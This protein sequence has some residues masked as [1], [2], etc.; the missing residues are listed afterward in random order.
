MKKILLI[1]VALLA[2][3]TVWAEDYITDVMVIGGNKTETDNLKASYT[4]Q[5]WTV[6][7]QD[8][9]AGAGSGSDYIYLLYKKASEINAGVNAFIT[10]FIVSTSSETVP[11][12]ITLSNGTYH[13]VTYDGSDYFK[14]NKGDLNS[15]CG[16]S[17][18]TIHL[19]YTKEYALNGKDYGTVKSIFFNA[20]ADGGVT[21][22]DGTTGYDLN[23]GCGSGSE[24]IYM[25]AD[26]SQGWI[27]TMNTAETEC[28]IKGFDGP[29]AN[30]REIS[31]PSS[32]DGAWVLGISGM[33]FSGFTN[34]ETMRFF[35]D[36]HV[37]QMPSLQGCS[38]FY[39][40]R[41]NNYD[42]RTPPSMTKIPG[43]AFAGTA[44][45]QISFESV[46]SIGSD[47]FAGCA[48][49]SSVTFNTSPVL[50][51]NSAFSNIS[52]NC[53]VSYPGSIEDW[54]PTM[55]MF[56]P[57][58]VVYKPGINSSSYDWICGWCG[59][60]DEA[61]HNMLYWTLA[62]DHLKISSYGDWWYDYPD[63]QVITTHNWGGLAEALTLNH[64]YLIG[65]KEF[66]DICLK[67]VY[68][69]ATL[70]SIGK[71]AFYGCI[72]LKDIWFDG[73]QQ[74]WN[75]VTKD[76]NWK[77]GTSNLTEHWHCMVIFNN[78]GHGSTPDPKTIQW[79]NLDKVDEPEPLVADGY[80][81]KGW[82][83]NAACTN[84]WDFNTAVPGDMT[85]YAGWEEIVVNVPGDVNCDGAVT[86][87]DVTCVYNY[88]L[89][90][91]ETFIA[92]SDV[93]GDGFITTVDITVI[94]NILLG[95]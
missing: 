62:D 93:D 3:T 72:N 89:N 56:S 35:T 95:N 83:T 94:Y 43:Y 27:F 29:K 67:D 80:N 55:Y 19:Y 87:A 70:H 42:Y 92:T 9:N 86:T 33:N 4:A 66:E 79:S 44:I 7:D 90:G 84:Q 53:R 48:N 81:F 75:A 88:L 68:V 77:G 1:L 2:T 28:I 59:G 60:A 54:G 21:T 15:H 91:D 39:N 51:E 8:L 38:K 20:T 18:A 26:K 12:N 23:T 76:A 5:G 58:L 6:I 57:N 24:Y 40:V 82:Y 14:N 61:S 34:L 22:T 73:N 74:Q 16:S 64:V 36:S 49:L 25:H 45:E 17:S 32:L 37:D 69:D 85:L 31:I 52:S 30:F 50:I 78:N 41:T 65:E 11:D 63:K 13:L 10:D 46:T 47:V 71:E